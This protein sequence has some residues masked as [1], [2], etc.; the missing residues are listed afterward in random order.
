MARKR[1]KSFCN[2]S[3]TCFTIATTLAGSFMSVTIQCNASAG[4]SNSLTDRPTSQPNDG[5]DAWNNSVSKNKQT[6]SRKQ[7]HKQKILPSKRSSG[8]LPPTAAVWV[9]RTPVVFNL[10]NLVNLVNLINVV[11]VVNVVNENWK[12]QYWLRLWTSVTFVLLRTN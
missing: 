2:L 12:K 5:V 8:G 9:T 1:Q 6:K 10:V 7:E 4:K 3:T 11:N